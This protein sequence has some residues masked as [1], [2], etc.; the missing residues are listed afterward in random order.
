MCDVVLDGFALFVFSLAIHVIVWRIRRPESFRTWL[1]ALAVIFGLVPATIAW[2]VAPTSLDA[3]ALLLL[4][5][6]LAIVYIIGY[7][8]VSAFS[9]SVELLKLLDRAVDGMP[10]SE[11]QLPFVA[12]GLTTERID[13]LAASGFVQQTGTRLGLCPRGVWLTRLVL[14][15]RHAIGL[16]DS[17]GG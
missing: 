10:I 6:S 13:N 14:L 3:A 12:G 11:L 7:T 5:G 1:P 8:L 17:G 9:P 4:H 2:L 15:Y 16:P